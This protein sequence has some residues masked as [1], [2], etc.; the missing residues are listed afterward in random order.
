MPTVDTPDPIMVTVE[1]PIGEL[2]VVASARTDT[3]VGVHAAAPADRA[4][5][6]PF[7][8]ELTGTELRVTGPPL[9]LLQKLT[10]RTPGRSIAVQIGLPAGSALDA[11]TSCGEIH[12]EGRLGPYTIRS[13][14][15]GVRVQSAASAELR[16]RSCCCCSC[17]PS[18]RRWAPLSPDRGPAAP[19]TS[20]TSPRRS[21]LMTISSVALATALGVAT[22]MTGGIVA[23][24]RTMAIARISVLTGHVVAAFTQT[25][26]ALAVVGLVAVAMGFRST[27]GPLGWLGT[28]GLLALVTVALTWFTVALGLAADTVESASNTPL[29]LVLLPFLSSG[30]VP[31]G[32]MP[33]GLRWFAEYQPFS[34]MIDALRGLLGIGPADGLGTSAALAVGWCVLIT[35]ASRLWARRLYRTRAGR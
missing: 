26:V 18:A 19:S 24:F 1:L 10:P 9:G 13:G 4:Q 31:T 2:R 5:A 11:R 8:I 14:Y 30:F 21:L 34:P 3:T 7:R 12:T 23:R 28:I 15:G 27:A 22:D 16:S 6:E 25:A 17:T 33:A 35:V 32:S 20:S 29:F